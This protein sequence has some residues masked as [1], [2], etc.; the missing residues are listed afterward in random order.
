MDV[1][2]LSKWMLKGTSY[3]HHDR[4]MIFMLKSKLHKY[5]MKNYFIKLIYKPTPKSLDSFMGHLNM[6]FGAQMKKWEAKKYNIKLSQI[7]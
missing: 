6:F 2:I 1:N 7:R 4:L 5:I 3:A